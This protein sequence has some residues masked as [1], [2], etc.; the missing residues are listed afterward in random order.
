[1]EANTI[2]ERKYRLQNIFTSFLYRWTRCISAVRETCWRRATVLWWY[3]LVTTCWSL[4]GVFDVVIACRRR[5]PGT[6]TS[7]VPS[8]P[9]CCTST[10]NWR[11]A[12][13]YTSWPTDTNTSSVQ[14]I[15][16]IIISLFW[17]HRT[18]QCQKIQKNSMNNKNICSKGQKGRDGTYNCPYIY[19]LKDKGP[20]PLTCHKSEILI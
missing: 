10:G 3:A 15:I 4:T 18:R 16:I 9:W 11:L 7:V 19:L 20:K 1:M 8:C 2:S 5:W 12:R 17:K 6:R 14:L 13:A